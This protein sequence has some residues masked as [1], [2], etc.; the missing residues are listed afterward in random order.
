MLADSLRLL[1]L[2]VPMTIWQ[3]GTTR[4]SGVLCG[5]VL[6]A[7]RVK[8]VFLPLVVFIGQLHQGFLY[9]RVRRFAG[10]SLLLLIFAS[11]LSNSRTKN[12]SPNFLHLR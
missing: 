3:Q 12:I 8:S 9:L 5:C 10:A 1:F 6:R 11:H 4:Q 7:L 2:T